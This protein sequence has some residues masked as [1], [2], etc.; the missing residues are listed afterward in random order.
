M[1]S[2]PCFFVKVD[3]IEIEIPLESLEVFGEKGNLGE[4]ARG[5][6]RRDFFE[7]DSLARGQEQEWRRGRLT[8]IARVIRI[9]EF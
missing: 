3:F 7:A 6:R 4:Q 8:I 9:D 2:P 1:S 5:S